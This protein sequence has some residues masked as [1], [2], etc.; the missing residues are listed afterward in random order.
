V[1]GPEF[2]HHVTKKIYAACFE[3]YME[4]ISK[5]IIMPDCKRGTIGGEWAGWGG[6]KYSVLGDNITKVLYMYIYCI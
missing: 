4:P 2:K 5:K 1:G 6:E 3:S